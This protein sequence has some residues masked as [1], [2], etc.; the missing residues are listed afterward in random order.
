MRAN[1]TETRIHGTA[2]KERKSPSNAGV[3]TNIDVIVDTSLREELVLKCRVEASCSEML[4]GTETFSGAAGVDGAAADEA[5]RIVS[6]D[7]EDSA[8]GTG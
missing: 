8:V 4:I 1:T 6:A 7:V 2:T 5:I 3:P